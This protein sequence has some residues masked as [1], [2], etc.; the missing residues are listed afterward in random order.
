MPAR[1]VRAMATAI[2]APNQ[3]DKFHALTATFYIT[4]CGCS[5]AMV[6]LLIIVVQGITTGGVL[7]V[8]AATP[9]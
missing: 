4:H 6:P 9:E 1:I 2:A 3:L 8:C 7:M 5:C